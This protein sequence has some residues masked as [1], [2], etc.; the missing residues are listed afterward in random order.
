MKV[1]RQHR[2]EPPCGGPVTGLAIGREPPRERLRIF[3]LVAKPIGSSLD[4]CSGGH[5]ILQTVPAEAPSESR[6]TPDMC[7]G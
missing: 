3:S 1:P 2:A 6:P 5:S 4:R 7:C